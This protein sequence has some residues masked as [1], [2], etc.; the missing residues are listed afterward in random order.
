MQRRLLMRLAGMGLGS[1]G[2]NVWPTDLTATENIAT[3]PQPL[4]FPRDLGSHPEYAVEW[5]YITGYANLQASN[6]RLVGFQITFFRIRVP[7]TQDQ[8]SRWAAKQVFMAHAAVTDLA[9]TRLLHDQRVMRAVEMP[10]APASAREDDTGVRCGNWWLKRQQEVYASQIEASDFALD[11]RFTPSQ[12]R[13]LQGQAGWSRKG[14]QAHEAS[15]YYSEPQLQVQGRVRL[16]GRWWQVASTQARAWLDHEWS[17]HLLPDDAVGWDWIGFNLFD[18]S[19]LTAFRLR[20]RKGNNLWAGGSWRRGAQ[21]QNFAADAVRMTPLR[22]WQSPLTGAR[23]PVAWSVHT[24][25]GHFNV[26]ALLDQQELGGVQAGLVYWEGLSE[27]R[28]DQG[29]TIGR[30]YL[31][32]TGYAQP[33]RR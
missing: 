19:A 5:W 17:Q 26:Q 6:E 15:Y 1:L 14:P 33:L 21:T 28:D 11:L 25:A 9:N 13:L 31:E 2:L 24:P 8:R 18:G 7:G 27:L 12:S 16:Q 30:G 32:M 3:H 10:H 22:F 4:V 23:Y 29:R 20:D